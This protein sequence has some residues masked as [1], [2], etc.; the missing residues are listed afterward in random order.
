MTKKYSYFDLMAER[1]QALFRGD[2]KTAALLLALAGKLVKK[3]LVSKDEM[4]G[5]AYI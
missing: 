3:G 2:E 1:K 4:L 5:G